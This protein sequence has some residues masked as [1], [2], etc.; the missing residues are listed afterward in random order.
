M[1][2]FKTFKEFNANNEYLRIKSQSIQDDYRKVA[3]QELVIIR[4][5]YISYLKTPQSFIDRKIKENNIEIRN[6][7]EG[8]IFLL[9]VLNTNDFIS[10]DKRW[11]SLRYSQWAKILT[12]LIEKG[13]TIEQYDTW[14]SNKKKTTILK[15]IANGGVINS[16]KPTTVK[17][18]KVVN[19]VNKG[20]EFLVYI[21]AKGELQ[22]LSYEAIV[23][24]KNAG[25][26]K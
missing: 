1:Q 13:F 4:E 7:K 14:V 23:L 15:S 11:N 8:T 18:F 24:L 9:I 17:D 2:K 22:T 20:K 10:K 5:L 21:D 16:E 3:E 6:K 12:F 25:L 26:I 19:K